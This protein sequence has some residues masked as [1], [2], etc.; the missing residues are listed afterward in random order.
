[1][2][3]KMMIAAIGFGAVTL[4][5]TIASAEPW[6]ERREEWRDRCMRI[7][8]E[9]EHARHEERRDAR[10][11]ERHEA[12]EDEER[13]ERERHEYAEHRCEEVLR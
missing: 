7:R 4:F 12:R 2:R 5:P 13:L 10:E 11:G 8:E 6:P 9:M 1:M 3:G